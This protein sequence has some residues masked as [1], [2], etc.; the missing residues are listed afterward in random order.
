MIGGVLALMLT[1]PPFLI[2]KGRGKMVALVAPLWKGLCKAKGV[3]TPKKTVLAREKERLESENHLLRLEVDRLR[4][5][6]GAAAQLDEWKGKVVPA[7]VIFR[8][9]S[10][11]GSSLWVNVG[12]ETNKKLGK[13]IVEK[14]SP[15]VL[16]KA[17]VGAVDYVG[18]KESRIRLLTDSGLKPSVRA[19]RQNS[20]GAKEEG[21]YLAKGVVHGSGAPLWRVKGGVLKGSGF[22]YDFEDEK[23][24]APNVSLIEV[25]DLLLT[26]GMDGL[27]PPGLK[28]GF[29]TKV[30]PLR[31]GAYAYDIEALPAAGNM[32]EL[33]SLYVLAKVSEGDH[34]MRSTKRDG[35][36]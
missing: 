19:W 13:V 3:V 2:E 22:N 34:E 27:F 23:G 29:V 35:P 26:T 25:G 17:V 8:D 21:W 4:G 11:Y 12:E 31:E 14:N 20:L 32:Q 18:K 16:G 5:L 10:S 28:V 15:V 7:R 9:P 33:K 1:L 30:F 6:L 24:K 36:N